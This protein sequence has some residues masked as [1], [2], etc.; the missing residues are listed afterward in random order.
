MSGCPHS[1]DLSLE[2]QICHRNF[3]W[4]ILSEAK[5]LLFACATAAETPALPRHARKANYEVEITDYAKSGVGES[6]A[7]IKNEGPAG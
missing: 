6:I 7:S 1:F 3:R 5:G 2:R 4:V